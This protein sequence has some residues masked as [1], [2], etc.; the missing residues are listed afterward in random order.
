MNITTAMVAYGVDEMKLAGLTPA[1]CRLVKPPRVAESPVALECKYWKTVELPV[2]PGH[3]ARHEVTGD[4]VVL[5]RGRLLAGHGRRPGP[6]GFS[7]QDTVTA[8]EREHLVDRHE[9][10][11]GEARERLVGLHHGEVAVDRDVEEVHH[12]LEHLPVLAR[13]DHEGAEARRL[14]EGFDDRGHF[15]GLGTRTDEDE[16]VAGGHVGFGF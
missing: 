15:D 7:G 13:G 14:L 9:Q 5:D 8:V 6:G 10:P 16:D 2:E 11:G 12:L 3:E 4:A 1:P